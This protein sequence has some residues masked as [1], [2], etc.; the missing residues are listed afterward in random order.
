MGPWK[1]RLDEAGNPHHDLPLAARPRQEQLVAS[2]EEPPPDGGQ[3]TGRKVAQ[4]ILARTGRKV[5]PQR[6]WEYLKRLG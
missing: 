2:L 6:G 3:W 4:W 5:H 1:A